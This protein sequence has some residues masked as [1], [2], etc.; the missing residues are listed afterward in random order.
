MSP[1]FTESAVTDAWWAG[2]VS[3]GLDMLLLVAILYVVYQ[4]S[5]WKILVERVSRWSQRGSA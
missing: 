1:I 2:W 4:M 5:G 3:G